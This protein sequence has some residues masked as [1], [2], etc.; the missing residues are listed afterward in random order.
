MDILQNDENTSI[1]YFKNQVQ[2]FVKDRNWSKYH[3]PKNLIQAL[4]IEV[5]ELSELFLFKDFNSNDIIKNNELL[6]AV[7]GEIADVF[8]YLI[9][10]TNSLNID[11]TSSFV[12]K[13]KLNEEKYPPDEFHDGTYYKKE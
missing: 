7:S 5:S 11:L 3:S 8:I 2:E 6:E 9:S 1:S 10:L 4:G 13:M 12:K